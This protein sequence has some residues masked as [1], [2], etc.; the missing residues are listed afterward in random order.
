MLE[1]KFFTKPKPQSQLKTR[2]VSEYF[3][4]WANVMEGHLKKERNR[5]K[6]LGYI[7][8]YAGPGVYENDC[9]STPIT[10]LEYAITVPYLCEN[11]VTFFNDKNPKFCESLK[12]QVSSIPGIETLRHKPE[13]RSMEVGEHLSTL[14]SQK[15]LP[16]TLSFIDPW[17]YKGLSLTLI[18]A[19]TKDWGCDCIFF[20][21]Y[22][23]INMDIGKHTSIVHLEQLFG[24]DK[25]VALKAKISKLLPAEREE[26]IVGQLIAG[27]EESC[28]VKALS[29]KFF[30]DD[31]ARTSHYV[32]FV[33]KAPLGSRIMKRVMAK[34]SME[35]MTRIPSLSFAPKQQFDLFNTQNADVDDLANQLADNFAGT[36]KTVGEIYDRHHHGTPFLENHYKEALMRLEADTIITI[37]PPATERR[38]NTLKDDAIV[39]FPPRD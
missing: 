1:D 6:N 36:A 27:V 9:K 26:E 37:E 31:S 7:D 21:N 16:P 28:K 13:F 8:L 3:A 14:F 39:Y 35:P 4:V 29:F 30:G 18:K 34:F 5:K 12:L 24:H 33:S 2:I 15:K 19:L 11:L 10:I 23:R 20:F 17:G 25:F 32:V 22:R 38:K